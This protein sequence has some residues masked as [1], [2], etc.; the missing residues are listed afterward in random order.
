MYRIFCESYENYKKLNN[1][2][3]YRS[4]IIKPI[5]L[6]VDVKK[7]NREKEE[8][9]LLYKQLCDLLYYMEQNISEYPRF[10]AFLWTIETRNMRGKYYGVA[11]EEDI[12]EQAKIINMFLKLVYWDVA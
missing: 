1:S 10:E 11:C 9:T 5:E 4:K 6:I 3:D 12:K 2:D 7:F 8:G